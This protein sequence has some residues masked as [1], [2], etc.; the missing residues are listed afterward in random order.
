MEE[1]IAENKT[2]NKECNLLCAECSRGTNHKVLGS[3]DVNDE[4]PDCQWIYS[5]DN[6]QIIQCQGCKTISFRHLNYFSERDDRDSDGSDGR[7]EYLYPKRDTAFHK[8]KDFLEVPEVLRRIHYETIE[9]FNN[10]CFTLCAAG[11]RVLV[12][13]ICVNQSV[14]DGPV[15]VPASG[16]GTKIIRKDNLEGKIA[17]LCEK[18]FLTKYY[19]DILHQ[20]RYLGNEALHRLEQPSQEELRLAVVIIEH[21]FEQL[22]EIPNKA[23][24]LQRKKEHRKNKIKKYPD[25]TSG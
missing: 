24:E 23:N 14:T 12:E 15:E 4:D 18:G 19:A 10:E 20:H 11:L 2:K 7:I 6:Y 13:G 25:E 5:I 21:I 8:R 17:G 1:Q 3:I 9:S 22:Y 16:G